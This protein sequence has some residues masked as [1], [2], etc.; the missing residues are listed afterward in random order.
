[1]SDHCTRMLRQA[2]RQTQESVLKRNTIKLIV[3]IIALRSARFSAN[4]NVMRLSNGN[5]TIVS[6]E[7]CDRMCKK[8]SGVITCVC[9]NFI[10]KNSGYFALSNF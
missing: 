6:N 2:A 10:S 8:K 4:Q 5:Q 9:R 7:N 3:K 1:M